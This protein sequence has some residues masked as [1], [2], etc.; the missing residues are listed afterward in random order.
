MHIVHEKTE[1]LLPAFIEQIQPRSQ[2]WRLIS[3]EFQDCETL[4]S[5][6]FQNLCHKNLHTFFDE[7][8]CTIFWHKPAFILIFF[9]GRAMPI[10]KCV[11]GFL[12]ETEF[13]GFGRF[14]DILD[15][16]IHWNNLVTLSQRILNITP[17]STAPSQQREIPEPQIS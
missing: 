7:S 6:L 9:Q 4:H 14:F 1:T 11:E 15:L 12:K 2:T 17:K 16:S 8:E 5:T 10:E 3:I 13:K